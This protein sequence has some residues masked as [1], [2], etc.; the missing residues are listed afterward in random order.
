MYITLKT[1]LSWSISFLFFFF[2]FFCWKKKIKDSSYHEN[3]TKKQDLQMISSASTIPT[4]TLTHLPS[5][6]TYPPNSPTSD[7]N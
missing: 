1:H 7:A 6:L 3:K 5:E 4:T 2:F